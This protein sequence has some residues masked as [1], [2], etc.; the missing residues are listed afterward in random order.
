MRARTILLGVG[1]AWGLLGA[2]ALLAQDDLSGPAALREW[3]QPTFPPEAKK[4]KLEGRV[5]VEFTVDAEGRVSEA[6]VSESTAEMFEEAAL[7]AVRQWKFSPALAEGRPVE[8]VMSV[9]IEFPLAQLKQKRVPVAP[10]D[11]LMPRPA[12]LTPAR[13][14]HA[15]DPEYPAELE[16][17][18][19]P[20]EVRLEFVVDVEGRVRAPRVLWASHP[21]FVEAALRAAEASS[22]EPARQGAKAR[23]TTARYPVSFVSFGAR[24]ADILAANQLQLVEGERAEVL[25]EPFVLT[26]PVYPHAL[27][28]AGTAGEAEVSFSVGADGFVTDVQLVAASAPE[29]GGAL[30]AAV[31]GWAFRPAQRDGARVPV[32]LRAART[33][34]PPTEGAEARLAALVSADASAVAGPRGLDGALTPLWRGFPVY[35]AALV[36]ERLSGEAVIEFIIDAGGRAR[37]PRVVSATRPEFGWAAAT[38]VSQWVF[39]RPRREGAPTDV[40]VSVPIAFTPPEATK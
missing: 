35:P 25:P 11:H 10:A 16:E 9:P 26:T 5:V 19:L 4:Q 2:P 29:F 6:A 3:V 15:P 14:K 13:A 8:C 17:K 40:R 18:K 36:A 22:F 23:E 28:L 38:A 32:K 33:F 30:V 1:L 37:L 12:K 34:S 27:L 39:A 21:A 24:R 31:D 20:G 7:A